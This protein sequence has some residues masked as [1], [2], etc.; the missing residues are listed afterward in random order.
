MGL[1]VMEVE[2]TFCEVFDGR[3]VR[4]IVTAAD[5]R[6]LR[7]A[8]YSSTALPSTVFGEAEGGLERWLGEDETP[9][10]R[11]GSIIQIWVNKKGDSKKVLEIELSKRIRQGILVVPTTTVFNALESDEMIDIWER[12]GHCGDGYEWEE[13]RYGRK[14]INIPLMMGEFLIERKLGLGDGFMGG[15]VWFYCD[16]IEHALAIGDRAVAAIE[17]V[18]GAI[19]SFDICAAGSKVET[20]YPE[21]GP[22]TNHL[23]CPTLRD[24]IPD[25]KVPEGVRSIPEIV[26]N[27]RSIEEIK[28]AM[29]ASIKAV[30]GMDGLLGISSGNYGG[31]LGSHK[32]YLRDL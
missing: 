9:D 20:N 26:I 18:E 21:I 14:M 23:Y 31:K 1:V 30:D 24:R 16:S 3:Y 17:E 29:R 10:G 28:E 2:D 12:V 27:A 15:N 5:S 32:I 7:R 19:T 8:T 13:E 25:S 11:S 4:L 6:R 22:T